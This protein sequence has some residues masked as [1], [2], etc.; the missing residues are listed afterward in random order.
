[1]EDHIEKL[2]EYVHTMKKKNDFVLSWNEY[3]DL[4]RNLV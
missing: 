1:M 2:L 4:A 3:M